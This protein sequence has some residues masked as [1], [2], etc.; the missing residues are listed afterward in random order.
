M[1]NLTDSV[2]RL[3]LEIEAL[4]REYP[5]L[6]EDEIA[7]ADM[8]EGA[9]NT[10]EILTAL[11]R[12]MDDATALQEG[13]HGRI[14]EL[15]QREERF[16]ARIDYLR[17]LMFKIMESA[18]LKKIELPEATLSLRNNPPRLVGEADPAAL[19]DVLVKITRTLNRTAI[20]AALE[21]GHAVEGFALSNAQP[22]L[23]VRVK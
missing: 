23:V 15:R 10:Q 6:A 11:A 7:R 4:L 14:A 16:L 9:T 8:L 12:L 3:R 13:V 18:N 5:I 22:S 20:R 17:S 2:D 1:A 21:S 19:P